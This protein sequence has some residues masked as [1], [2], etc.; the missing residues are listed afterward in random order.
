[1]SEGGQSLP[2]KLPLGALIGRL[3]E[4]HL[5]MKAG[6]QRV[7]DAASRKDFEGVRA[8]LQRIDPVFRRHI[9]DEESQ[10]LGFIIGRTGV[11]GAAEEIKVFQQHRPIYTLMKRIGEL[12]SRSPAE[13]EASQG[14]L[15]ELFELHTKAE[16]EKVFPRASSLERES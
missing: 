10:I 5:S 12:S 16:E 8:E 9:A 14:E 6:I 1:M 11:K 13:L 15:E 7:R 4:E 2:R 3:V